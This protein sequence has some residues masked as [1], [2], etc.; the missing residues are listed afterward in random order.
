M[1]TTEW[2]VEPVELKLEDIHPLEN[3]EQSIEELPETNLESCIELLG[4]PNVYYT[5]YIINGLTTD[6]LF[7]WK[8]NGDPKPSRLWMRCIVFDNV[9]K[10]NA[11]TTKRQAGSLLTHT[12]QWRLLFGLGVEMKLS[13]TP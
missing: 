13:K 1:K 12:D 10:G 4:L 9:G 3:I 11:E 5:L 6:A 8:Q 2:T 7:T